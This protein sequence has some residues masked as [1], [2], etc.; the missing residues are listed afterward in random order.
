MELNRNHF[1]VLGIIFLLIGVQFRFVDSFVLNNETSRF[2]AERMDWKSQP[3]SRSVPTFLVA[4]T[5]LS[6]PASQRLVDPPRWL[7]WSFISVGA[8]MFLYSLIMRRPD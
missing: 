1:F 5:P 2:V 7:G 3:A 6:P 8:V 4:M